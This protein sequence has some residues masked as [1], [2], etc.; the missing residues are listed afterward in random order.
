MGRYIIVQQLTDSIYTTV[1]DSEAD[2]FIK[3]YKNLHQLQDI[4]TFEAWTN[5]IALRTYWDHVKVKKN[6]SH[7]YTFHISQSLW[8]LS[9]IYIKG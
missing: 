3:V 1:L 7:T 4:E 5:R 2:T 8:V 6:Q 9:M